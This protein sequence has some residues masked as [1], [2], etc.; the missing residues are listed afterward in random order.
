[1]RPAALAA[2]AAL[3]LLIGLGGCGSDNSGDGK[4]AG[5]ESSDVVDISGTDPVGQEL[6]GSVTAL[7][8][9][10]D[11]NDANEDER[12][13][14]IADIRRT[15]A[16]QTSAIEGPALTDEEA[17]EVFD[18]SCTPDY[19]A[20]FRLYKLYAQAVGFVTLKRAAEAADGG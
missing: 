6:A 15:L 20:G 16:P 11:W 9:C 1:M 3:L 5:D 4:N 19:A 12:I 17:E 18:N 7:V 8:T 13:A 10:S 14:T 2:V